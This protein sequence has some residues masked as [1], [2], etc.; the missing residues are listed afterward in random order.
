MTDTLRSNRK[1]G[2]L[3]TGSA[4][5]QSRRSRK[6]A[7]TNR[8]SS[9]RRSQ[10]RSAAQSEPKIPPVMVRSNTAAQ[11][12]LSRKRSKTRRRYDVALGVPGAEMRLPALPQ[13]RLGWRL[14]SL[15][16][17]A[18]L[19][20]VLY[21]LW[22]SPQYQVQA[23]KVSGLQRITSDQVNVD[24]EVAGRP[25]FILNPA[26][27][28]QRLLDDFPEFKSVAVSLALPNKVTVTVSERLPVL[29]WQ[30]DGKSLFVDA[31]G[32]AFAPQSGEKA[33]GPVVQASS[34]PPTLL[35]GE[36]PPQTSVQDQL[37]A[38][39]QADA[40]GQPA[41][42]ASTAPQPD[43]VRRWLPTQMV[44]GILTLAHQAPKGT[45]IVYDSQHGLGWKDANGWNVYFG[46]GKDMAMKL[47]VYKAIVQ[48]LHSEDVTPAF[49]SVEYVHAPYYHTQQ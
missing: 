42:A 45:P 22:N 26:A 44:A 47:D 11:P 10:R 19:G 21:H 40:A 41:Q 48:Q 15:V 16:M 37:A 32:M 23:V 39:T 31:D 5:R 36:Q 30:Q 9:G 12:P 8:K 3:R 13:V 33:L 17:V 28:R 20:A 6:P 43:A 46:D 14:I 35:S 38:I 27:M 18:L 4:R 49:I 1:T 7:A 34:S 25:V 24:L 29:T 2:D